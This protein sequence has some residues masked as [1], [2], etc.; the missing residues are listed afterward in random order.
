M[1]FSI[2]GMGTAL[3]RHAI[4]QQAAATIAARLCRADD[5]QARRLQKLYR[6]TGVRRR[7]SIVLEDDDSEVQVGF[8]PDAQH[9]TDA[10]PAIARRMARYE[11]AAP[12]LAE[13]AA[14]KALETGAMPPS[15]ITH[16]VTVTCSGF[17]SPGVDV[18]IMDRLGLLPTTERTQVGFMGCHGALNGLRVAR[19]FVESDPDAR[20][21]LVAVELCSIHYQYGWDTERN[22]ANALFADGAAAMVLGN[23]EETGSGWRGTHTGS[24]LLPDSRDAMTWR[25][26]DHGFVM[27]LSAEVPDLIRTH[28]RTWIESFLAQRNLT[29][30]QVR[31]WAVHPG[32]PAILKSVQHA[33]GLEREALNVSW[34]TLKEF[35]NMSSPTVLFILQTLMRQEAPRPCLALGFGPGL[36]AEAVLFE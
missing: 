11:K 25:I 36:V 31:S 13:E 32:G 14:R 3:P 6:L 15:A 23:C 28:L 8:Y 9:D 12:Q 2:L 10:G 5:A 1:G 35:G 29:L 19:G 24:C 33:L 17:M 26:R 30:D 7:H 21:L 27:T 4:T 34:D 22:V 16:I 18:H 20:V